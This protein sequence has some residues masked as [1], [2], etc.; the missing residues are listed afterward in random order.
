MEEMCSWPLVSSQTAGMRTLDCFPKEGL[1]VFGVPGYLEFLITILISTSHVPSSYDQWSLGSRTQLSSNS[2]S[3]CGN[4]QC[5]ISWHCGRQI[6]IYESASPSLLQD[7][8]KL[9]CLSWN[10]ETC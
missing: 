9:L 10:F 3:E 4:Q 2:A 8:R 6:Q 5:E 1:R 7:S